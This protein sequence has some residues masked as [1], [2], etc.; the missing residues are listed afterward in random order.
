VDLTQEPFRLKG[1]PQR[2]LRREVL[3]LREALRASQEAGALQ[4]M[5][6]RE[7]DHRI[8]NSLQVVASLMNL[9]A[10]HAGSRSEREALEVAGARIMSIVRI[11]DALQANAHANSVN[12][13]EV[14]TVL[15]AALHTLACDRGHISVV[16][17]AEAMEA[18][19]ALAQP[20][21]I[22]VNELVLNALSH[23]FP[24][25]R[26]GMVTVTLTHTTDQLCVSVADNGVGLPDGYSTG[27][28]YGIRLVNMMLRQVGGELRV[29]IDHGS[30]FTITGPLRQAAAGPPC[31]RGGART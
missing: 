4:A 5:L 28:G 17:D 10:G 1:P 12:L 2:D 16:V 6:L 19:A 15:C 29:A 8:K 30:S 18:P 20:L 3:E 25:N 13:G 26:K 23:A 27:S 14:L 31:N 22:A 24:D 21:A 11:H 7:G 9:Q